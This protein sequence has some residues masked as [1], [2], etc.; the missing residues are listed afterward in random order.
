MLAVLDDAGRCQQASA[1]VAA[2]IGRPMD[3]IVGRSVEELLP[4]ELALAFRGRLAQIRRT[5][6]SI[7]S[8]DTV[9]LKGQQRWFRSVLF[10]MQSD[11]SGTFDI[12]GIALDVTEAHLAHARLEEALHE[13]RVLQGLLSICAQCKRIRDTEDNAWK[14][15]ESFVQSHSAAVFSHGLCPSC[16]EAFMRENGLEDAG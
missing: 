16:A 5:G 7:D 13:N 6:R 8:V 3:R 14:P 10:P 15:V 4:P 12:G 2:A 1:S 11:R 9:T